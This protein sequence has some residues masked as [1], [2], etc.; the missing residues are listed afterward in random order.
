LSKPIALI[1]GASAGIGCE[2]ARVFAEHG[3]D[4]VLT[5]RRAER[6]EALAQELGDRC[7]VTVVPADLARRKGARDLVEDLDALGLQI[8]VLVNNAGVATSGPFQSQAPGT[9]R[10]IMRV[11]MT[12][13]VELTEGLLPGMLARGSGRI[14]NV[15]SVAGFQAVP[16]IALYSATKAF[17]LSFSEGLAEDL[18]GTGVTV[19]A[20]CPGPTRTEMVAD[21]E[22]MELAGPFMASAR[23]VAREGYRACMAGDVVRVP[24]LMNQAMVAWLQYQPR[25]L[26]RFFSGMAA[27]STFGATTGAGGAKQRQQRGERS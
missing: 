7:R 3:H 24:G 19:T 26:V 23:E 22:T 10:S 2:L 4:L 15:A 6:L 1:T 27:R 20:L 14:L 16:G 17:V 21:I 9:S 5:A 8:D 12:S 18:R 25:G 11:N 13:L